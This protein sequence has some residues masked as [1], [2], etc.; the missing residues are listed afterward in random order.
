MLRAAPARRGG[1]D[2]GRG[3]VGPRLADQLPRVVQKRLMSQKEK[4]VVTNSSS[5]TKKGTETACR[6]ASPKTNLDVHAWAARGAWR[7]RAEA[8]PHPLPP[9]HR[10]GTG[11]TQGSLSS[12]RAGAGLA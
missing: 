9:A 6:S 5:H 8:A 3:L 2:A 11:R 1:P 4:R 10:Q 7:G 12:D